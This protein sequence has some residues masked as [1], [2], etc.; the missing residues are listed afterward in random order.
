MEGSTIT[1]PWMMPDGKTVLFTEVSSSWNRGE[2]H[3]DSINIP[4]RQRKTLL[5]NA[6]HAR[7]SPTGHLVLMRNADLLTVVFDAARVEISGAPMPL[8]AGIM[9][10]VN[11]TNSGAETGLGQFAASGAGQWT[12]RKTPRRRRF[13]VRSRKK[14]STMWSQEE[15]VG[16]K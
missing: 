4:T 10:A 8:V 12:L 15:L 16:V 11:A 5:T 9:Q 2:A 3:V 1:S 7:Y 6:T 13:L 14:R